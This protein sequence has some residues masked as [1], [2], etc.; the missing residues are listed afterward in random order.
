[1]PCPPPYGC[2][3]RSWQVARLADE[4]EPDEVLCPRRSSHGQG[5]R[6]IDL[7]PVLPRHH[8]IEQ[9][10]ASEVTTDGLPAHAR[11]VGKLLRR[12]AIVAAVR[13]DQHGCDQGRALLFA[14]A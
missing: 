3:A 14:C 8:A 1:M 9:L 7:L 5:K 10:D 6:Q 12:A 13:Q 2:R 4:D 11:H